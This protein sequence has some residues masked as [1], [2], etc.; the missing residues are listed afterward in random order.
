[1]AQSAPSRGPDVRVTT[2]ETRPQRRRNQRG[3][4]A[5]LRDELID[6]AMRILYRSP[7]TVLTLR[8]V[9]RE[10]GIARHPSIPSSPM[11]GKCEPRSSANAGTSSA[12]Q[13]RSKPVRRL[14]THSPLKAQLAAYVRYAMERPSRYQL[15]F[16]PTETERFPD[17]PGFSSPPTAMC[18]IASNGSRPRAWPCPAKTSRMPLS[19]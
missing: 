18:Y 8:M 17:I 3:E 19:L 7:A 9:A 13:W 1:M 12:H 6:A 5:R 4:G 11:P 10:A 16:A 2:R 15:L 14:M